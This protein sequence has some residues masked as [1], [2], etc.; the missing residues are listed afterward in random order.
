[1]NWITLTV[2]LVLCLLPPRAGADAGPNRWIHIDGD[3]RLILGMY[4]KVTDDQLLADLAAAGF[5][6]VNTADDPA[7]LDQ[8]HRHGIRAWINLGN[9]LALPRLPTTPVR[10]RH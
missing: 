4:E 6:L 10:L 1:M 8:L 7:R 3:P 9:G 2:L 5:N